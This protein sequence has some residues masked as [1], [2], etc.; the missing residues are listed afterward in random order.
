M[1]SKNKLNEKN[2]YYFFKLIN[3]TSCLQRHFVKTFFYNLKN[4]FCIQLI[5]VFYL[6]KPIS[7]VNQ[8]GEKVTL[9]ISILLSLVVFLLLVS[10]ILPPTSLVLPLIAKY[11]LF[12]FIMNCISIL[13]TVIIINCNFRSPRTH[14]MPNWT[15]KNE[16][17][18]LFKAQKI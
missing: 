17:I 9:G 10:K 11:L 4:S 14:T 7:V 18:S 5:Y 13:V 12:T 6:K 3:L 2:N 8:P 1:N 15:R 16:F